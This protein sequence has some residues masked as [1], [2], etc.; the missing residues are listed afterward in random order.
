MQMEI[1]VSFSFRKFANAAEHIFH[2][3]LTV[4][5]LFV[6][7]SLKFDVTFPEVPCTLLSVDTQDISGEQ[8]Y[9]IVSSLIFLPNLYKNLKSIF[10]SKLITLFSVF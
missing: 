9:D 2:Q 6:F 1:Y 7:V 10:F 3:R 8:H 4:I 5:I